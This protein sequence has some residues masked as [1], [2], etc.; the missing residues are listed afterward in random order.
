[1]VRA[2]FAV[3]HRG[4]DLSP[5]GCRFQRSGASELSHLRLQLPLYAASDPL[6]RCRAGTRVNSDV[7][8]SHQH[9]PGVSLPAV[10]AAV[11]GEPL[12]LPQV[13][14]VSPDPAFPVSPSP[15]LS[16]HRA[17]LPLD[18]SPLALLTAAAT[19]NFCKTEKKLGFRLLAAESPSSLGPTPG[20][21]SGAQ[22]QGRP[23]TRRG[24]GDTSGQKVPEGTGNGVQRDE[25]G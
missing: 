4:A 1:M 3:C 19:V 17:A 9:L 24:G 21:D 18:R 23:P 25:R 12:P 6:F 7:H 22:G 5:L 11:S 14:S 2:D 8:R 13:S 16:L 20:A 15:L 10:A